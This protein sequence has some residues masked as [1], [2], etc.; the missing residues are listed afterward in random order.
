ME[1]DLE[2]EFETVIMKDD[3]TGEDIEFVIIDF[4]EEGTIRYLLV[5]ESELIDDDEAEAILL[6]QTDDDNE[7]LIYSLVED[8]EEFDR[9]AVLFQQKSGEYD[10]EIEE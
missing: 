2:D 5:I 9:I 8:D 3:D 10:V 1:D 4:V 7:E 6:K